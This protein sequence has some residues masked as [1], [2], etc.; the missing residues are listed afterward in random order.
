[1]WAQKFKGMHVQC[2]VP[3]PE[4]DEELFPLVLIKEWEYVVIFNIKRKH[5]VK[6]TDIDTKFE[7]PSAASQRL[8]F[9]DKENNEH[10]FVTYHQKNTMCKFIIP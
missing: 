8:C 1:M 10:A 3:F 5:Y 2:I 4:F 7:R 6:I 9:L